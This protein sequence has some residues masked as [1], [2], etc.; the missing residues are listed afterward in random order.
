MSD[1]LSGVAAPL[2]LE[3]QSSSSSPSS[4]LEME[5]STFCLAPFCFAAAVG[6]GA[7]RMA[8]GWRFSRECTRMPLLDR[9]NWALAARALDY[10]W[11]MRRLRA[12]RR[13]W[14]GRTS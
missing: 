5:K 14:R 3:T 2:S 1:S 13:A 12:D 4:G 8:A 6:V 9:M 10:T 7:R 11:R